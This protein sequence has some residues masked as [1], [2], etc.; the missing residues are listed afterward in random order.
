LILQVPILE[1]S[2]QVFVLNSSSTEDY[3]LYQE[4]N[5]Y[6]WIQKSKTTDTR[7]KPCM[8]KS[9]AGQNQFAM[10]FSS[11]MKYTFFI[12]F[13]RQIV[14][15]N[16][17]VNGVCKLHLGSNV[18]KEMFQLLQIF[19]FCQFVV[20]CNENIIITISFDDTLLDYT[21]SRE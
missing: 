12:S 5:I 10:F 6:G 2:F 15:L 19:F 21:K 14:T 20:V 16:C 18:M 9:C 17:R 7:E 13:F 8:V 4:L 3:Y 1:F 11:L